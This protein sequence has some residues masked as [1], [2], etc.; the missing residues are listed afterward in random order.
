MVQRTKIEEERNVQERRTLSAAAAG[1]GRSPFYPLRRNP[2]LPC[3]RLKRRANSYL[4][5]PSV[6]IF[7]MLAFIRRAPEVFL[8][9]LTAQRPSFLEE[10]LTL[11]SLVISNFDLYILTVRKSKL[12]EYF[13]N[14]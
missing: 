12:L 3:E 5:C 11:I 2:L 13:N 8:L 9:L 1:G 10:R 6:L 14:F 4:S 7:P